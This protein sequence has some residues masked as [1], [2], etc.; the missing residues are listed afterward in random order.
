MEILKS[1]VEVSDEVVGVSG[2]NDH[3]IH[4]R[5]NGAMELVRQTRLYALW[6]VATVFFRPKDMVL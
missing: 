3:V 1:L 2:P 5:L 4:V 6:Y